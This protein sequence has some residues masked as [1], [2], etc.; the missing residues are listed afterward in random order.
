M[1][2]AHLSVIKNM[3]V[4]DPSLNVPKYRRIPRRY[5]LETSGLDKQDVYNAIC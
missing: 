5:S 3:Y 1:S 2:D 4:G